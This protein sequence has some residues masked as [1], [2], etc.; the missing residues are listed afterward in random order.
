MQP[1]QGM[2]NAKLTLKIG[3]GMPQNWT[4]APNSL[5]VADYSD[6]FLVCAPLLPPNQVGLKCN[7]L[8][9]M[10]SFLFFLLFLFQ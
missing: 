4:Y 8:D 2:S 9:V 10:L 5:F 3:S 1:W 7:M 6:P